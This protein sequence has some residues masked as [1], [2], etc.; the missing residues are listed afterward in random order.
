MASSKE[1]EE[2]LYNFIYTAAVLVF[3][4]PVYIYLLTQW[5]A[6]R[7]HFVIRNRFPKISLIVVACTI[8]IQ[9]L[10][11]ATSAFCTPIISHFSVGMSNVVQG[12]VYYRCYLLYAQTIQTRQYLT[13][14]GPM[15]I[16][17]DNKRW[18]QN[19]GRF[20]AFLII[21]LSILITVCRYLGISPPIFVAFTLTLLIG[22]ICL[23]NIIRIKVK[24]SIGVTK[25]CIIQIMINVAMLVLSGVMPH[26]LPSDA[27][28]MI[29]WCGILASV[30]Y[31]F[32]TLFIAYHLVRKGNVAS[33]GSAAELHQATGLAI[34]DLG[35]APGNVLPSLF[36]R[37]PESLNQWLRKPLHL[38]LKDNEENLSLFIGYLCECFALENILFLERAIVL[39]HLITKYQEMD[40]FVPDDTGDDKR[41][42]SV[43]RHT[44]YQLRFLFLT[45]I[46]ADI[47]AIIQNGCDEADGGM[48]YRAEAI[49][50]NG[51]DEADGGMKYRAGIVE[52][53]KLI[54]AQFCSR[55]SDTE[56]NVGYGI[57]GELRMLFEGT[58]DGE[59]LQQFA[60]YEDLL[61][62]YHDA[63]LEVMSLCETI[64]GFQFKSYLRE[65][66]I[67]KQQELSKSLVDNDSARKP[68]MEKISTPTQTH[69]DY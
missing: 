25:E 69:N 30:L 15:M 60:C 63:I 41:I 13:K 45:P 29:G 33:S 4:W 14:M 57:A 52:A 39:H 11:I 5:Y 17:N 19:M 47:E 61:L 49:I 32:S 7:N 64:Y 44:S 54:Y 36:I 22:V 28:F 2:C 34:D 67:N 40:D 38:F 46:Y 68:K 53:M 59:L 18:Y 66:V 42:Q 10:A 56:I 51:C 16:R 3:A 48:K 50:Q 27:S 6:H 20:I 55:E 9:I 35:S 62:V 26:L 58:P 23:V 37:N 1:E 12:F 24:D 43:R 8:I 31:G 65:N 21:T